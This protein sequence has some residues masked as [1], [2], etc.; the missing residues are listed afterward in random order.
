MRLLTKRLYTATS[1]TDTHNR[2]A[3]KARAQ[4]YIDAASNDLARGALTQNEA[5]GGDDL[6]RKVEYA[7]VLAWAAPRLPGGLGDAMVGSGHRPTRESARHAVARW[8][9]R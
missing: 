2:S 5:L 4:A 3:A 8:A 7:H 6:H 1:L 9:H